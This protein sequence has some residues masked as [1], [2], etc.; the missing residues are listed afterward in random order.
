[1][2]MMILILITYIPLCIGSIRQWYEYTGLDMSLYND[3]NISLSKLIRL[4]PHSKSNKVAIN[5][6]ARDG[7]DH[8]PVYELYQNYSYIGICFEGDTKMLPILRDNMKK[9][10]DSGKIHIIEEFAKVNKMKSILN[11]YKIPKDLDVLKVDIDSY[12]YAILKRY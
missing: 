9:I 11:Y 10:N 4:I 5:I 3:K 1:M 8:D 6:G 12:D 2:M 7:I